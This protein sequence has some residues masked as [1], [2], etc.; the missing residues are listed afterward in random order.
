MSGEADLCGILAAL[1]EQSGRC[2]EGDPQ[3]GAE[4]GDDDE[5]L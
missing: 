2:L 1:S 5:Y 4:S 3:P